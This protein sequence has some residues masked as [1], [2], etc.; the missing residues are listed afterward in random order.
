MGSGFHLGEKGRKGGVL[1]GLVMGEADENSKIKYSNAGSLRK[2]SDAWCSPTAGR[3][4]CKA[5]L[6][7]GLFTL[8]S[9]MLH[10]FF[11]FFYVCITEVVG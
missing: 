7:R 5:G 8:F 4:E 1:P 3:P 2:E 6:L 9:P 11:F 10:T